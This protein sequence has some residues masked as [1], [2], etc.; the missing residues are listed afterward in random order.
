MDLLYTEAAVRLQLVRPNV[1]Y[2]TIKNDTDSRVGDK[3]LSNRRALNLDWHHEY[4][5]PQRVPCE[6]G[7]GNIFEASATIALMTEPQQV[8]WIRHL[9]MECVLEQDG[10]QAAETLKTTHDWVARPLGPDTHPHLFPVVQR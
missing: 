5:N 3:L 8:V 6:N 10:H 9:L 7:R 2:C 1:K 4:G